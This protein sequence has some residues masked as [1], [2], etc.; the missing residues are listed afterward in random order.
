[1]GHLP[2]PP[3]SSALD[4]QNA[5]RG[6]GLRILTEPI[7]SPRSPSRRPQSCR[8][9]HKPIGCNTIRSPATA[10][11]PAFVRQRA[12]PV[13]V[14][15]HLDKADIVV[16]LDA[17]FLWRGPGDGCVTRAT[18]PT[19]GESP[20]SH[21][22]ER[23][24]YAA[25]SSPTMTGVKAEHRLPLRASRLSG[26]TTESGRRLLALRR[27]PQASALRSARRNARDRGCPATTCKRTRPG[28]GDGRRPSAARRPRPCPRDEPGARKHRH[29]SDLRSS[30]ERNPI[31]QHE[32][33]AELGTGWR[34]AS[35]ILVILGNNPVFTAPADARLRRTARQGQPGRPPRPRTGRDRRARA[36]E[37]P[38]DALRWRLGDP[39]ATTAP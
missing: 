34:R 3:C 24:I 36:L 38:R 23:R 31:S 33:L 13:N 22:H 4:P 11:G 18:S 19:A 39:R 26:F 28:R 21:R 8:T 20:Q 12:R 15:Y 16:S 2:E 27:G 37:R 9:S 14:V 6:A 7:T 29:D 35:Q 1:M 30:V 5:S 17:D 32:S 25:E 10:S